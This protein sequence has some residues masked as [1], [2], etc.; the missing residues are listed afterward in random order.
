MI[1]P[2]PGVVFT[3]ASTVREMPKVAPFLVAIALTSDIAP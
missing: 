3:M 2:F 1:I